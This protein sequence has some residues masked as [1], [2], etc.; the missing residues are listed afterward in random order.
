[1]RLESSPKKGERK[2]KVKATFLCTQFVFTIRCFNA[3]KIGWP[4][5]SLFEKYGRGGGGGGG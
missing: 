5:T 2:K 4:L 3:Q 1:M